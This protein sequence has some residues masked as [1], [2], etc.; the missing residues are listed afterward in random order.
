MLFVNRFQCI[1]NF[2]QRSLFIRR[3]LTCTSETGYLFL[4]D[5][6]VLINL[7]LEWSVF[8]IRFASE[9]YMELDVHVHNAHRY[10][11]QC[12]EKLGL[13]NLRVNTG[14]DFWVS[15]SDASDV[16]LKKHF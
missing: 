9:A 15:S 13:A 1:R 11:Y 10:L 8:E 6:Y 3:I 12:N 14:L 5:C 16:T 4:R 7:E 2:R